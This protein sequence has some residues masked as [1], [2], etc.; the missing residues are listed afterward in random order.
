MSE[1]TTEMTREEISSLLRFYQESGL[2]FP[3]SDGVI[4]R[5]EVGETPPVAAAPQNNAQADNSSI[6]GV[7]DPNAPETIEMDPRKRK[8]E[9]ARPVAPASNNVTMPSDEV[10]AQ[11]IAA[12][13]AAQDLDTLKTAVESFE[14]CNLKRS[15]R[16]T[17]FE[18]GKRGARL[19][20]IGGCPSRED[21]VSGTA[22]S[23]PDGILLEKMLGAIG[24]SRHDDVYH[25]FCVPWSPPGGSAPTPL[26]L[27]ICAPFLAKQ[28]KLAAPQIVIVMGNVAA[29]HVF[30]SKQTVVQL[31]G[32]WTTLPNFGIDAMA[33]FDPAMLRAQPRMKRGAWTDLLAIKSKLDSGA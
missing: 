14:G 16:S 29:R 18:G 19:M 4:N 11:A 27:E 33:M 5:F 3:V 31:R 32:K 1:D 2:D 26:H 28:I 8:A 20:L 17:V 7:A 22:L 25:G 30:Q 9:D 12:A 24:L 21:D 10:V 13:E 15:A 6:N 23:G